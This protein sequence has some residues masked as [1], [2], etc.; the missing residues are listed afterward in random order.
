MLEHSCI[1]KLIANS[2]FNT[3]NK[4][5]AKLLNNYGVCYIYALFSDSWLQRIINKKTADCLKKQ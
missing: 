1:L 4:I 2:L 5:V 3:S